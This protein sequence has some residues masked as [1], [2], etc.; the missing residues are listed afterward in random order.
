MEVV[1]GE[2]QTRRAGKLQSTA[3]VRTI[4]S[5]MISLSHFC[6]SYYRQKNGNE[7]KGPYVQKQSNPPLKRNPH[8]A[9]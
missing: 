6:I 3:S 9:L 7:K 4:A 2:K 8:P 5:L 1:A